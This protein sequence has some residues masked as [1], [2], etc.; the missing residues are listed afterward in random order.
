M[1]KITDINIERYVRFPEE[2]SKEDQ[3]AIKTHL[4]TN[5]EANAIAKWFRSFYSE[6]DQLNRPSELR[7]PYQKP[8]VGWKGPMVLAA[9]SNNDQNAGLVT[10]ATYSSKEEGTLIRVLEQSSDHTFQIHVLSKYM[11]EDD[12]VLIHLESK[13]MDFIT[14]KGG[15]LRNIDSELL[16][17]LDLKNTS[18]VLQFPSSVCAYQVENKQD[19]FTVCTDCTLKLE[20]D[21]VHLST[22]SLSIKKIL[23]EQSDLSELIYLEDRQVAFKVNPLES[24]QVYLFR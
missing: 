23:L 9:D 7:L 15:I 24:F 4:S 1:N 22:T 20:G 14:D 21:I 8:T 2:L 17:D 16:T 3:I 18:M 5:A 12:R 6:L 11:K 10:K 19:P 13:K